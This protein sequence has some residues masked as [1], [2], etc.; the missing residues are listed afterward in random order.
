MDRHFRGITSGS[1][2]KGDNGSIQA[3][4]DSLGLDGLERKLALT[5]EAFRSG[6]SLVPPGEAARSVQLCLSADESA[7][8]NM[9]VIV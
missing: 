4:L 5:A 3:D 8:T 2:P 1:I 6:Q 9:P 7:R